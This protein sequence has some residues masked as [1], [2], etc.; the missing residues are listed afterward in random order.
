MIKIAILTATRAEYGLMRPLI[1]GMKEDAE[2]D[3]RLLVTGTHLSEQFGMTYTEIEADGNEIAEKIDILSNRTGA[4]GVSETM[5]HALVKFTEYFEKDKPDFLV[6]DGDR[7]EALAV[8]IAATNCNIPIVH[9]GGGETTQGATDECYRHAITKMSL[10][11]FVSN[12]SYRKRVIQM[13]E[14]PNFVK[15]VGS[16]SLENI[17]LMK[18]LHKEQL[19]EYLDFKLD[20]PY[21]VVTFHPVTL[22]DDTA[23][24]QVKELLKA[25]EKRKNIKFIFTKANAD[26]GGEQINRLLEAFAVEHPNQMKCVASLGSVRYLSALKYCAFVLGNSSSGI[27][28]A[29]S[30][31]IPTVNIGDRQKGRIQ[32]ES[33]LNCEPTRQAISQCIDRALDLDFRQKCREVKNPNGDGYTSSRI[34]AEIKKVYNNG[35]INL[36]KKFFDI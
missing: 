1:A 20:K 36:K 17:R 21:V 7:Y 4:V 8:A 19:E 10:L 29:P 28:E 23:E 27:T 6:I 31:G 33:I 22:E 2:I 14:N 12:E 24:K 30:F 9:L 35:E 32:A 3:L 34:I 13:G 11:H 15:V 5:G 18:F 16:V 25:C 26:R